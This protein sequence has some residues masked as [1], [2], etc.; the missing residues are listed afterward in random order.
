MSGDGT[1]RISDEPRPGALSGV[2]VDPFW[3]LLAA[4]L[5][6]SWLALPWFALNGAAVG[7]PTWRRELAWLALGLAVSALGA[8]WLVT[9][10]GDL[11]RWLGRSLVVVLV[12]WRLGVAYK[13]HELQQGPVE[14][15]RWHGGVVRGG[16]MIAIAGALLG[17]R[18]T[19]AL[20]K[21]LGDLFF[22]VLG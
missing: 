5:A 17:P 12:A 16:A 10:W 14:L 19:G 7:S 2:V 11:P 8:F 9:A 21:G 15:F 22:L 13:V 1:Y 3:P 20:P 4:M 18:I 6:G